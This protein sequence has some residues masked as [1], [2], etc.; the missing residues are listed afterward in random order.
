MVLALAAAVLGG[1]GLGC[2]DPSEAIA[3]ISRE[4]LP[5]LSRAAEGRPGGGSEGQASAAAAPVR[6]A[7]GGAAADEG[8]SDAD[9]LDAADASPARGPGRERR[10]RSGS[11]QEA[12]TAAGAAQGGVGEGAARAPELQVIRLVVSKG[13]AGR[14]PIEPA[15]SFA[16]AEIDRLYAFVELSNKDQATSEISV[17]FTP[18]DGGPPLRIPLAVGAQRRFR[19]WA[20]TRK[21]RAAGLWSVTVSDAAGKELARASF[22]I[23][24]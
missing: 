20:A 9:R 4:E 11:A 6:A 19:T 3:R 24:K 10:R 7:A 8:R 5:A 17:A 16:S 23:T 12:R 2:S 21:A 1:A 18:P 13:I 14:E 15:T 22:T